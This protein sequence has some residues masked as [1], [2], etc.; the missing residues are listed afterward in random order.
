MTAQYRKAERQNVSVIVGLAGGTGSGKTKTAFE[1]ATGLAGGKPFG[2]IDTEAGRAMH[3]APKP[4]EKADGAN[5]YDFECLQLAAPFSPAAYTEAIKT[6][7]AAGFPVIVVDQLSY[8]HA[9]DG[10]LLDMAEGELDR[11]AGD[12]YEKRQA[13]LQASWI[14]PKREHKR[15]MR[16]LTQTKAHLILCFRAEEKTEMKKVDGRWKMV[17]MER[18][19]GKDG[20]IPICEKNIP[21]E[22]TCSFLLTD[23]LP[24][25]PIPIKLQAQHK[26]FFPLDKPIIQ[27]TGRKLAEWAS[28]RGAPK[29]AVDADTS[30]GR[31]VPSAAQSAAPSDGLTADQHTD[32][33]DKLQPIKDGEAR[34]KRAAKVDNLWK[35]PSY[36]KALKWIEQASG[37]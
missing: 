16:A 10:G 11:M 8:E 36:D 3:Y 13:C 5:T 1:L 24:G 18:R 34:L 19:T 37:K 26:S 15:M 29:A 35:L 21:F 9:G 20:W 25:V 14:K 6:G 28:V 30:L 22:A 23:A 12:N 33:L 31:E 2:V 17:P 27:D 7:D 4:G 32:I